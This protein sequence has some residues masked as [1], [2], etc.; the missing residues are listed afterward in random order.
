LTV[1]RIG[2]NIRQV[3]TD[4]APM[5][6]SIPPLAHTAMYV[7]HKYWGR[8]TWNVVGE[9]I[10]NHTQP[11]EIVFDP[12]AGSGV[13]AIEALR[14]GRKAIICDLN[15]VACELARLTIL[16]V[17]LGKLLGAFQRVEAAVKEKILD[18]YMTKCRACGT[19]F[20]ATCYVWEREVCVEVR[21]KECPGCGH[22]CRDCGLLKTDHDLIKKIDR[23][24]IDAW[25][26]S[27]PLYYSSGKPFMKKEHFES[28]DQVFTKRNLLALA[29]LMEAIEA[30]PSK[31]LRDFLKIAF[32]S[33]VHLCSK[34]CPAL[35][36]SPTNHQTA[37]SSTWTQHSYW[38]TPRS[39][40]Q[41]VWDKY[42]S[43]VVGHQGLIKAKRESNDLFKEIR[44]TRKFQ[45]V[46][47]DQ[48]DVCIVADDCLA[49]MRK[50]ALHRGYVDYIFTDPPYDA[51]I[52]YGEL[53]Y[54]WA[55]WL[56]MNDGYTGKL[57]TQEIIRNE[58]QGKPFDVYRS[59][60]RNSFDQMFRVLKPGRYMTVTFHNPTFKVRNA[61]IHEAVIAG[62]QFEN[63]H[64][65][66]LAQ[67]S[68]K[69]MLQ[70]FGSAQGDFYMR[71]Q[72]PLSAKPELNDAQFDAEKFERV[73]IESTKQVIAERAEP[74]PYTIIINYIDPQLAKEGYWKS[75][76]SGL[77][78]EAVLQ[79]HQDKEF[80]LVDAQL[81]GATGKL[82]WLKDEG[83]V[84][85]LKEIPLSERVEQ[86]IYRLL[87]S[88]GR[89]TF[90]DAWNEISIEFP[91][92]LT[93]DAMSIKDALEVYARKVGKKGE[94]IL[95][96]EIETHV[97]Q[98]SL[99]IERLAWM[100]KKRGYSFWIGRRE[101]SELA[102]LGLL[103]APGSEPSFGELIEI[104][105]LEIADAV[106]PESV[107]QMDVLWLD[108]RNVVAAFEVEATTTMTSALLRG[109]NL[110]ASV[111]KYMLIPD[112]REGT[113]EQKKK[114]PLFAQHFSEENWGVIYFS[115][116][117]TAFDRDK[118]K[119]D[120]PG[121][122]GVLARHGGGTRRARQTL[123]FS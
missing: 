5:N 68:A 101:Q 58:R 47:L 56:K 57:E 120:L 11:G 59:L 23:R 1:N 110:P 55:A 21:Y 39:T 46:F 114:S 106:D 41:N 48:A 7:W 87:R 78:V 91:N 24:K 37:F 43:A 34:M 8:K 29:W 104:K 107:A 69:S 88:K 52:Q 113:L 2:L 115:A 96:P 45:D 19:E 25:Y 51:S 93:S 40:E 44:F 62:Y 84:R 64:H 65:Q 94:W 73:V 89:V 35:D 100:G 17:D 28:L 99:F 20:P 108:G 18:L 66:P 82:W 50:M 95:K 98:H 72:K 32:S 4:I 79:A 30:E 74:T 26:P 60:L 75:H 77:D 6:R 54:L 27:N 86:T 33:M 9:Y 102:K 123:L 83:F 121:L 90:T 117:E 76:P 119:T 92:S 63:I 122:K 116:F 112:E 3:M 70:P 111:P 10:L 53:A 97:S 42:E 118:E 14:H 12:F 38:S 22:S 16:P 31:K 13:A 15:P 105:K 85:R 71:F 80:C 61:T 36:S 81:G 67:T 49:L 103:G 109:S